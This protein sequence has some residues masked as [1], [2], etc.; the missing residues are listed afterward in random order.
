MGHLC[1]L[2]WRMLTW[3]SRKPVTLKARHIPGHLNVVADKLSRLG[4]TIQTEWY[5]LSEVFHVTYNRWQQPQIDLFSMRFNNKLVQFVSPVPD[6]LAWAV[7]ALTLPWV[8]LDPY[9]FPPVTILGKLVEKLQDY[10][11]R[12]II[13]IA[14]V[15]PNMPWF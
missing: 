8:D 6:P 13:L 11:C 9:A 4:H 1:A 10:P 15:W 5:L 3:C 12:R 14:P 7:S 2:L